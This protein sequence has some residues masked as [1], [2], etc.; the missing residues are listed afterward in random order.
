[1]YGDIFMFGIGNLFAAIRRLT[2]SVNTMADIF[3]QCNEELTHRLNL[4]EQ[5]STSIPV[6]ALPDPTTTRNGKVKV[7][8]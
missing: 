3:D 6:E 1:M 5:E 2:T 7:K 8:S 4:K